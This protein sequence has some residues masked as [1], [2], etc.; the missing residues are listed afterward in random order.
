MPGATFTGSQRIVY[1]GVSATVPGNQINESS[2][3]PAW[4][5]SSAT[6][7]RQPTGR[8]ELQVHRRHRR[9]PGAGRRGD[10]RFRPPPRQP[11]HRRLAR[12]PGL[13]RPPRPAGVR[14]PG[15]PLRLRRQPADPGERPVRLQQQAGRRPL[16]PGH[17]QG[18]QRLGRTACTPTPR[19]TPRAT[20]PTP[21]P[22]RPAAW[23]ATSRPSVRS[24]KKVGGIAPG[25]Q[26]AEYRVCGPAGC[27]QSDST[28][29]VDPGRPRRRRRHQLLHRRRQQPGDG[30]GRAGVP[31]RLRRRRLRRRVRRQR[32]S[33][34]GHGRTR[35]AVGDHGRGVHPAP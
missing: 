30:P 27:Y 22:P 9:L 4:S 5:P 21:P 35:W 6:T 34:C 20:A 7:S 1:G 18:G 19:V 32:R 16:L 14:R 3:S 15:D 10:R 23:S 33:G 28:S 17:L 13:R 26:I 2:P 12:A 31:R 29:A 24:V 25:A 11:R 8:R